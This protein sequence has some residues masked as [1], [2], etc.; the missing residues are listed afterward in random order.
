MKLN[1]YTILGTD[2]RQ[3]ISQFL[4]EC[5]ESGVSDI[6]TIR[7]IALQTIAH[8]RGSPEQ[9]NITEAE[10]QL[11]MRWYA[12]LQGQEPDW[13]VY[14]TDYYL[15]EMWACWTVYSRK[16]L[17]EIQKPGS[18]P[19]RGVYS[20]LQ[21]V[22]HIVD[23]GCGIG[24]TSAALKQMFPRARVTA[25]NLGD[26]AQAVIARRL[27]ERFGFTVVRTV[28]EIRFDADLVFASE[29]FEHIPSPVEHLNEI[30]AALKPRTFLIANSFG[31]RAIGHFDAYQ[32]DGRRL[33]SE[34]LSKRFNN[35]LRSHGYTKVKTR[36]W[37][38]RPAYWR[39]AA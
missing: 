20:D 34:L 31:T 19:P 1:P 30:V 18:L 27:G 3:L 39:R 28:Q 37:N 12:S 15:A 29:Y 7:R 22:H 16:Y 32:V 25:T 10:Q 5:S 38:G 26:T 36:L 17:I 21:P 35:S 24:F 23:L 6:E 14:A 33:G 9:R 2:P 11:Q 8:L 4:R 13:S